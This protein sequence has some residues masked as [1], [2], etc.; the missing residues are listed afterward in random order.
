MLL[1]PYLV[2]LNLVVISQFLENNKIGY[3]FIK[4]SK[5]MN[6]VTHSSASVCVV[7]KLKN[8]FVDNPILII[9]SQDELDIV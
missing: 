8:G 3:N 6:V 4:P 9:E 2:R 5:R 7:G 1:A